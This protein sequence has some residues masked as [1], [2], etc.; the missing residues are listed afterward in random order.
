[1]E[2]KRFFLL[3]AVLLLALLIVLS[4]TNWSVLS[5]NIESTPTPTFG[6]P[7]A[8]IL[9]YNPEKTLMPEDFMLDFSPEVPV[10]E[11]PVF[12]VEHKDGS[13]SQYFVAYKDVEEF[14][15]SLEDGDK[16]IQSIPAENL[17]GPID[18]FIEVP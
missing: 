14:Y 13:I 17:M 7:N 16:V 4:V 3:S 9:D 10:E 5:L 6:P 1:M 8:Q 11:K 18:S 15:S 2:K 12:V